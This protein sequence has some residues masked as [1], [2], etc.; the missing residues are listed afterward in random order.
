MFYS[1][2]VA[3]ENLV[4]W[5]DA[6]GPQHVAQQV[7]VATMAN[8]MLSPEHAAGAMPLQPLPSLDPIVTDP[9]GVPSQH[10]PLSPNFIQCSQSSGP[11][12]PVHTDDEH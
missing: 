4:Q 3:D 9:R 6:D 10:D 12:S 11:V 1:V 8:K 5:G 2:A 7:E